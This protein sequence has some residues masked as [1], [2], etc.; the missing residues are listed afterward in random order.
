MT[1]L[2]GLTNVL[3][4]SDAG[5]NIVVAPPIVSVGDVHSVLEQHRVTVAGFVPHQLHQLFGRTERTVESSLRLIV[6][7]GSRLSGAVLDAARNALPATTRVVNAYGLT[8]AFRSF[9][10][11]AVADDPSVIGSPLP[12]VDA[13]IVEPGTGQP[14]PVGEVGELVLAGPHLFSGYQ[15]PDGRLSSAGD[16]LATGD[17]AVMDGSGTFRLV[18]RHANFINVGGSKQ[19]VESIEAI[20][21]PVAPGRLAVT[22]GLD[23]DGLERLVVIAEAD[24]GVQLGELRRRCA[25]RLSPSPPAPATDRGRP[26]TPYRARQARPAGPPRI[27]PTTQRAVT[28]RAVTQQGSMMT[29]SSDT[30]H[31]SSN[32]FNDFVVDFSDEYAAQYVVR[33]PEYPDA[34]FD[35]LAAEA[36]A[37]E[38]AWDAGTGTGELAV[39]LAERFGRVTA[40]D[41]NADMLANARRR[42]NVHYH[43]WQSEAPELTD[44]SV[45]LIVS[46]M[47]MHWFDGDLFHPEARRVLRADGLLASVGF[48]FFDVPNGI[49]GLVRDWYEN[50]MTDFESPQLTVLREGFE[51]LDFPFP[52]IEMPTFT[53]TQQWSYHQLSSFLYHWIVVKRAREAGTEALA[54]LLPQMAERW[55]GGPDTE[56]TITWPLFGKA[57]RLAP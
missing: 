46:G 18:G 38:H 49:G 27:R 55:P 21:D 47:A 29:P 48:Y 10:C 39:P 50:I 53:M 36:P 24:A 45:D 14:T 56:T 13:S 26:P 8:E 2:A 51:R 9:A 30:T 57:A 17:M 43:H 11:E 6:S 12:G 44:D 31:T 34:L 3:A 19:A 54:E 5:A 25:R 52:T 28:Q 41:G 42:T 35:W 1:H 22:S 37:T 4:A 23:E 33:R 15:G 32:D 40:S 16:R 7:S 20:L